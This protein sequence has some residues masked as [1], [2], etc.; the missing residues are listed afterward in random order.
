MQ[1]HPGIPHGIINSQQR[2]PTVRYFPKNNLF[3]KG[4]RIELD[5]GHL[6]KRAVVAANPVNI[7]FCA[8]GHIVNEGV[9][10][11]DGLDG[12]PIRKGPKQRGEG[13][14]RQSAGCSVFQRVC[15]CLVIKD[16]AVSFRCALRG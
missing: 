11:I 16:Y 8:G 15:P 7:L 14:I 12:F 4:F 13:Q 2:P 1:K 9:I 3:L 10:H 6:G 5:D